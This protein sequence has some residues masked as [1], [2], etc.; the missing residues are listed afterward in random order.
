MDT[1]NY[2]EYLESSEPIRECCL[3]ITFRRFITFTAQAF[4]RH[5]CNSSGGLTILL[6]CFIEDFQRKIYIIGEISSLRILI[7]IKG[8]RERRQKGFL[9]WL[10]TVIN[11]PHMLLTDKKS[12][13]LLGL[14]CSWWSHIQTY[15]AISQSK[16]SSISI[17]G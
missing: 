17:H 12:S 6:N 15:M 14:V 8:Q 4:L 7:K 3:R 10:L 9:A 5:G 11:C 16:L 2:K 1:T 13:V